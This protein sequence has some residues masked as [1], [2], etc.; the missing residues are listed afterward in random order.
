MIPRAI[1]S[2]IEDSILMSYNDHRRGMHRLKI[3]TDQ[4]LVLSRFERHP[5]TAWVCNRAEC[6]SAVS[7]LL[8]VPW[9][10]QEV[11]ALL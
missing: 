5:G 3:I 2:I 8:A 4:L 9:V 7:L 1:F 6:L 10:K 11:S